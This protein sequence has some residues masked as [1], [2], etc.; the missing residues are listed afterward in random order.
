M[1]ECTGFFAPVGEALIL[2]NVGIDQPLGEDGTQDPLAASWQLEPEGPSYYRIRLAGTDQYLHAEQV[3]PMVGTI[4]PGWLSAQWFPEREGDSVRWR[5]R[6][7]DDQYLAVDPQTGELQ[8]RD[9][10]NLDD[11]TLWQVRQHP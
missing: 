9:A 5:N 11:N 6:W 10:A 8:L 7:R 1:D 2:R 3:Q 4:E